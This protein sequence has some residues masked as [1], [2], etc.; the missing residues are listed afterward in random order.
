MCMWECNRLVLQ[1][2]FIWPLKRQITN[3]I[4]L[5][6]KF[7]KS[8]SKGIKKLSREILDFEKFGYFENTN[9]WHKS[10]F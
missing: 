8:L 7:R 1:I 4:C 9:F 2:I 10:A 6:K 3:N 5:Y